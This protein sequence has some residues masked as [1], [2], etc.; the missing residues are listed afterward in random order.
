MA[1]TKHVEKALSEQPDLDDRLDSIERLFWKMSETVEGMSGA[2]EEINNEL[3]RLT[4]I[5]EEKKGK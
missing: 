1:K 2:V 3:R 5:L 4:H